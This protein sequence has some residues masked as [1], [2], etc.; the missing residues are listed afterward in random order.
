MQRPGS[1]SIDRPIFEP[2]AMSEHVFSIRVRHAPQEAHYAWV[3]MRW[4]S[5]VD[6]IEVDASLPVFA[7]PSEALLAGERKLLALLP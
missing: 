2:P 4:L 1:S 3:I 7:R 6:A 5:A